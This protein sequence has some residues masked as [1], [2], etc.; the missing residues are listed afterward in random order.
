MCKHRTS[1]LMPPSAHHKA[2][3]K[4][5]EKTQKEI[6]NSTGTS[7]KSL[8]ES[9]SAAP[10]DPPS[11]TVSVFPMSSTGTANA[12]LFRF[13]SLNDDT[14]PL[15][16]PWPPCYDINNKQKADIKEIENAPRDDG[17][18]TGSS[19]KVI[20]ESLSASLLFHEFR[21]LRSGSIKVIDILRSAK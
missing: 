20:S 10:W 5:I 2:D 11:S 12:L 18:N 15:L 3:T 13:G 21:D 7:L 1:P 6:K 9:L 16:P 17:N 4:D 19:L 14:S 8:S